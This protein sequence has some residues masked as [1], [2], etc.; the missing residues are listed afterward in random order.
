[1]CPNIESADLTELE[2]FK[3]NKY[4]NYGKKEVG[5][6]SNVLTLMADKEKKESLSSKKRTSRIKLNTKNS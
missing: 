6:C 3:N 4:L 1:M 2:S 5:A